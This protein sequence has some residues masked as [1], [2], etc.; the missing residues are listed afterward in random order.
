MRK[1]DTCTHRGWQPDDFFETLEKVMR[2]RGA[3]QTVF[4]RAKGKERRKV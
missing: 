3:L 4:I 2:M 1:K